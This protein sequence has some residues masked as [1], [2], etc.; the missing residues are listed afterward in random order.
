MHFVPLKCAYFFHVITMMQGGGSLWRVARRSSSQA[1][2]SRGLQAIF[3]RAFQS[4]H[5]EAPPTNVN[6]ATVPSFKLSEESL[7]SLKAPI[8]GFKLPSSSPATGASIDIAPSNDLKLFRILVP[9]G[10][11]LLDLV[12]A[13]I[14]VILSQ[15]NIFLRKGVL[16]FQNRGKF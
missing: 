16:L 2:D 3:T 8:A 13:T 7:Q 11:V 9:W 10:F 14:S 12:L 1:P 5:P 15:D 4:G 6:G